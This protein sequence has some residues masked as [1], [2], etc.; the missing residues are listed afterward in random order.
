MTQEKKQ[1]CKWRRRASKASLPPPEGA[2]GTRQPAQGRCGHCCTHSCLWEDGDNRVTKHS[3][4]RK[5]DIYIYSGG[6]KY[7]K[8]QNI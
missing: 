1:V 3:W 8:T 7:N 6:Y 4:R 2:V 5:E